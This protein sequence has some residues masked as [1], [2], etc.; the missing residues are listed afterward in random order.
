M[1]KLNLDYQRSIK[2][3][4]WGGLLL[5]V[6]ALATLLATALHYRSL[7][8]ESALLESRAELA[9]RAAQR[10]LPGRRSNVAASGLAREVK[11]ANEALRQLSMPWDR[12]F[13]TVEAAGAKEVALLALEP[14]T[15]KRQVKISGE[16][17]NI[18]AMLNYIRQLEHRDEFGSVYLQ[19][20]HV[21]QQ[22]P[23]KPVRFVL[24]AIWRGKL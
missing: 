23:D 24:L 22:D 20:H 18:A 21:Q 8:T 5:L 19:S 17:K 15:E 7:S 11:R 2:P 13:R 10:H 12:L 3:F 14:D 9:D 1:S 6:L 4:P 16:A